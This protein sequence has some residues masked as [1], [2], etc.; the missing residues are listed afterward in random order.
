MKRSI[1]SR[2]R[3]SLLAFG[4]ACFVVAPAPAGAVAHN[5]ASGNRTDKRAAAQAEIDLPGK[6]V[7]LPFE[8]II[9]GTERV[10]LIALPDDRDGGGHVRAQGGDLCE[11]AGI[12]T[13]PLPISVW[14]TTIDANDDYD[15]ACPYPD[16]TAPD[17]VYALTVEAD[18]VADFSLCAGPTDYDTKLYIYD[19]CPPAPD[20]VVACND[21]ACS[22]TDGQ[23]YVSAIAGVPL[24]GGTTYYVVIDGYA[25]DAG[26]YYLDIVRTP[27]PP[28]CPDGE[29]TLLS[30]PPQIDGWR[31]A[32]S[33][34][35]N[36]TVQSTRSE[37]FSDLSGR[38]TALRFWG[39]N[40]V[41]D[42]GA[43]DPSE[44][45]WVDCTESPM[46]FEIE[47]R[48]RA[49][50]LA[51]GIVYSTTVPA[52][53]EVVGYV[54]QSA[55]RLLQYDVTLPEPCLL[56]DGWI[57]I[58]G[59]GGPNC[60]FLW[61]GSEVGDGLS[62]R[63]GTAY[64]AFDLALCLVTDAVPVYGACCDDATDACTSDVTFGDC[65]GRFLPGGRCDEFDPPCGTALGACCR[66]YGTDE[67]TTRAACV[68]PWPCTGDANCDGIVSAADI[69]LFVVA[70]TQGEPG[71]LLEV[72]NC[73]FLNADCNGDGNVTAA[74]IDAFVSLLT[75]NS[76]CNYPAAGEWLGADTSVAWC[77]PDDIVCPTDLPLALLGETCNRRN[78]YY[79]PCLGIYSSGYDVT[80]RLI[81]TR[82]VHLEITAE[83]LGDM[84]IAL[85]LDDDYPP[86]GDCLAT[87]VAPGTSAATLACDRLA[88][89]EYALVVDTW[90]LLDC[91]SSFQLSIYE[92]TPPTGR[93]CVG[94]PPECVTVS[95]A[96]CQTLGGTWT[97][98][99]DCATPCPT[100]LPGGEDCEDAIAIEGLPFEIAYRTDGLAAN[101]PAA[102]C[103]KYGTLDA[104]PADVWFSW[105][106]LTD[107][108][109][110]AS[111]VGDSGDWV[112]VVR[113]AGCNGALVA[114]G[115]QAGPLAD[116]TLSFAAKA[117]HV[118]Y[119][120]VGYAGG[121]GPDAR[122][123]HTMTFA[124]DATSAVG[125]CC[126][127]DGFC[128]ELPGFDCDDAGGTFAGA[129]T[130]CVSDTCPAPTPGDDCGDPQVLTLSP[131]LLPLVDSNTTAG[132]G[133]RYTETCLGMYDSG[134]EIVYALLLTE[135]LT[136][137]ITLDPH[138]TAY[139][140]L[141]LADSC[142]PDAHC[143]ARSINAGA[144]PHG[145]SC[146]TLDAGVY[147]LLVDKWL[148]PGAIP[149][150]DLH[151]EQRLPPT[152][153]CCVLGECTGNLSQIECDALGGCWTPYGTCPGYICPDDT[154]NDCNNPR[155]VSLPEALPFEDYGVQHCLGNTYDGVTCND[156]DSGPDAIYELVVTA[157]QV[158]VDIALC[159]DGSSPFARLTLA[160][161]CPPTGDCHVDYHRFSDLPLSEGVYYLMVD[162]GPRESWGP[163]CAMDPFPPNYQLTIDVCPQ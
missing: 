123:Q 94:L 96:D 43:A 6:K 125:A 105:T 65:A 146:L 99:L 108:W 119:F 47:F 46:Q 56:R 15:E 160:D 151:I 98:G 61:L 157:P 33:D 38:I 21:D 72:P 51:G 48:K 79:G 162:L 128:D 28:T 20:G 145:L 116:E 24:T 41:Y 134:E 93:C 40:L 149:S 10:R 27:E 17:V 14:G 150:F 18:V 132:R 144:T 124:L 90:P 110:T 71:Y 30:Q 83:P 59:V 42:T 92:C 121:H 117:E 58:R 11:S 74:D 80:Y 101:G 55:F 22:A 3:T 8:L 138:D 25:G 77:P 103:D 66:L 104:M 136:I 78:E 31:A 126:F 112:I 57:S 70:L 131:S 32:V 68:G 86:A 4:A 100:P 7:P 106:P 62:L 143:R 67:L 139:T 114:C 113:D 127:A 5:V 44:A 36:A 147:Y 85:A 135:P 12:L 53:G 156:L 34:E 84:S 73:R 107:T 130:A 26:T 75:A 91:L 154:A 122:E 23:P 102:P 141:L 109:A 120:Q 37:D 50:G 35:G 49:D 63:D 137:D 87:S 29:D 158:C 82:D 163:D 118:Y 9:S 76:V 89:G 52:V 161:T 111:A 88:P 153:A 2:V 140:G 95:A 81:V 148:W 1:P 97:A 13:G 159:E 64:E 115:D 19:A 155:V 60:W 39:L 142:P 69:G 16:S 45:G 133:N 129:G 54:G 152:G